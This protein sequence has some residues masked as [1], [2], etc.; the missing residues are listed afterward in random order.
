[1]VFIQDHPSGLVFRVRVQP[2]SSR[3]MVAG[4]HGDALKLK[5]NAPPVEGQANKACIGFL[6]EALGTSKSSLEILAGHAARVKH[7]LIRCTPAAKDSLRR[8]IQ[9]LAN[10]AG[11]S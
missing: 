7:V 11:S 8:R 3:N 4:L 9:A 5:L 6:A 1:M 10:P 2:R